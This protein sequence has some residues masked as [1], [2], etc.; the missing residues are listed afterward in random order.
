MTYCGS[1]VALNEYAPPGNSLIQSAPFA[2]CSRT[3]AFASSTERTT[4]LAS[5]LSGLAALAG[6]A[7]QTMPS[8]DT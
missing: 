8:V 5:G 7:P 6:A 1:P 3:A 4:V 2:I